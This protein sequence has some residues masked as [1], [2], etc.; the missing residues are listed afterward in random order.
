MA[1]CL[2][3]ALAAGLLAVGCFEVED[4]DYQAVRLEADETR[5]W[6]EAGVNMVEV[7]NENGDIWLEAADTDGDSVVC[8]LLYYATGKDTADAQEWLDKLEVSD[9]LTGDELKLECELPPDYDERNIGVEFEIESPAEK[10]VIVETTNGDVEVEGMT[11]G[12]TVTTDN[13]NIACGLAQFEDPESAVLTT[14]NGNITL[15]LPAGVAA[16]FDA[17]LTNGTIT[18]TGFAD[19][20]YTTNEDKHKAGTINGGGPTIDLETTNGDIEIKAQ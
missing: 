1:K 12:A 7:D 11:A 19:V 8:E 3:V 15:S 10:A 17:V 2:F 6:P 18:L 4:I 14:S 5:A 16:T 20:K 9:N 13:G